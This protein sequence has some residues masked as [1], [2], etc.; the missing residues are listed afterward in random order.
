MDG[1]MMTFDESL[2]WSTLGSFYNQ[3]DYNH[4]QFQS[5]RSVKTRNQISFTPDFISLSVVLEEWHRTPPHALCQEPQTLTSNTKL[6]PA[7]RHTDRQL[8]LALQRT[9]LSNIHPPTRI[10]HS[11]TTQPTHISKPL[12]T[13]QCS[14]PRASAQQGPSPRASIPLS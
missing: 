3:K 13:Q 5:I 12:T 9:S 1:T 6:C 4:C 10:L 14:H 8:A 2:L 11:T 7:H